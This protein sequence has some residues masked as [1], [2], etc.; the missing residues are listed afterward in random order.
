VRHCLEYVT[1]VVLVT[2]SKPTHQHLTC[3]QILEN[4]VIRVTPLEDNMVKH[5]TVKK[6]V[7]NE[8]AINSRMQE[9]LV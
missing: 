3:T 9:L 1:R 5:L 2:L 4:I 7:S 6:V 8:H